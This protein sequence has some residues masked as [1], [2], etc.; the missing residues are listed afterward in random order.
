VDDGDLDTLNATWWSNS[1]GSWVQFASNLSIAT[2]SGAVNL[3]QTNS[4]FSNYG[5]T[6]WWSV[7]L[8]DETV[9][10]N[11]TYYFT[12]ASIA[13]SVDPI[14]PYTRG[15]LTP[16]SLTATD[17]SDLGNV[18]LYYR[19]S[20]DNSSWGH[21]G[22]TTYDTIAIDNTASEPDNAGAT[23][24]S[25]TH[26]VSSGLN[27]S[28]LI[29]GANLEDDDAGD[30][31]FVASADFNGDALTHAVRV[32]ADEGFTAISEIWYLLSPD[33][34]SHTITVNFSVAINNAVGGSASFSGVNQSI[35]DDNGTSV[36]TGS[37]TGLATSVT[38]DVANSLIIAVATDGNSGFTF[39]YGSDQTEIYNVDG[40][41]HHGAGS[42]RVPS[43]TGSYT[44][45]TN[46]SGATNRMSQVVATWVPSS[47]VW[48]NGTNWAE[49]SDASNPDTESPWGWSFDYPNST[50]Y[51]EFYSI[52]NKS[53]SPNESAPG[54]ADAICRLIEN[55][56]IE[57]IPSQWDI[58]T[59]TIGSNNYSTSDYYFNLT[60]NGTVI[61]NIQIKASNATNA[62]TGA[63]WQHSII[64]AYNITGVV[65]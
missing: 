22:E 46:L 64:I 28:I 51:Y 6:Y 32:A 59:T 10:T 40:S 15:D 54:S 11:E 8:T 34:G 2:S 17:G 45:H 23:S 9:W 20:D 38:T 4:N 37:P 27:N 36:D 14:T 16:L 44:M 12:T 65:M 18:T 56:T 57:I 25:W 50:G 35:P 47:T 21:S 26:T 43:G 49:W 62:T 7:N 55:T 42:Y 13:T 33:A 63:Q 58:G 3:I 52:G 29:V 31:Y 39:S 53:G 19:W 60:N 5:A 30:N 24:M 48:G 61:L 1:S 41:T